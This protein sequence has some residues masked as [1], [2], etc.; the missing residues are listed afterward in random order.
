MRTHKGEQ[1]RGSKGMPPGED[2]KFKYFEM[3][4]NASKTTNGGR[5]GG[6]G[7]SGQLQRENGIF[8]E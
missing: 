6:G 2:F 7:G 1:T 8:P 3:A 5:G 4:I